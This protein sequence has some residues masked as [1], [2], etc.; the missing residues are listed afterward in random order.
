MTS[1]ISFS[2]NNSIL[3]SVLIASTSNGI[4][5]VSF[6]NNQKDS[7]D[8]L[9]RKFPNQ[10][11]IDKQEP[12]HLKVVNCINETLNEDIQNIPLDIQGTEFQKRVW[13]ELGKIAVGKTATY[14][15]IAQRIGSPKAVR[16]V[17]NAIGKNPIALIIPC[18]RVLRTSGQLGGYKWG[19]DLKKRILE[20][21]KA[22]K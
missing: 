3:G 7:L 16:A 20:S 12:I 2:K 15:E 18:H 9:K 10:T 6:P 8:E 19:I 17:G 14:S 4:C 1:T 21:E 13:A 11:L 22:K 5:F